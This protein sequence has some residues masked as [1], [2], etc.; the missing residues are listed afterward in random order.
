VFEDIDYDDLSDLDDLLD[1]PEFEAG[2]IYEC[3]GRGVNEV[4]CAIREHLVR[5]VKVAR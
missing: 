5:A 1:E 3:C 2:A 4:K